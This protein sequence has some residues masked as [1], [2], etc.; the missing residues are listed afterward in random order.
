MKNISL[1]SKT[2]TKQALRASE[3][4]QRGPCNISDGSER[5]GPPGRL[6]ASLGPS[7]EQ[8]SAIEFVSRGS[9]SSPL[10]H[11]A[12]HVATRGARRVHGNRCA[13]RARLAAQANVAPLCASPDHHANQGEGHVA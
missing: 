2:S 11:R 12:R 13:T 5:L 3:I 6:K 7:E 1:F 9:P 8:A 4:L 10:A